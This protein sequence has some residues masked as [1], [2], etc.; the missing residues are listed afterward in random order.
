M[1]NI[2]DFFPELNQPFRAVV[3]MHQKPDGDALGSSLAL[4][5]YLSKLG[6]EVT[7]I[8][9]TNWPEFLN[10]L[11][12][13]SQVIDYE[14]K[15]KIAAGIIQQA[16]YIFCLDFNSLNRTKGLEEHLKS[17]RAPLILLDH[18]QEPQLEVFAFGKSDTGKGSTAEMVYDFIVES[19]KGDIID[20]E[21]AT[22]LY[23]GVMTDTG[24]FRFP[25]TKASAHKMIAYLMNTGFEH[26]RVHE[27]IFD[28]FLENRLRFFGHVLLNRMDVNYELNTVLLAIP[29]SDI[30]RFDIKTGDTEGLVNYPLSMLG[31][32]L[33]A[34]VIDRDEER[35][36]SFRSKG[37]VDVNTFARNHFEGGGHKNAAGGKSSLSLEETVAYF[38]KV[39][40]EMASQLANDD[41]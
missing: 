23:T 40:P 10:W 21:M 15:K 9:P 6:H 5:S 33:A 35:K 29:K 38:H 41:Y 2:E 24:S 36:W 18:H 26:S 11:P 31:I 25:S 4:G 37:D 17:A 16:D 14:S 3:T 30:Q 7:I 19:E 1:K 28:T 8:S 34:I 27:K 32:K 39:L 13:C 20:K 22:C 12:G